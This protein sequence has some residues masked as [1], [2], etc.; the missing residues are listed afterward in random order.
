MVSK[1]LICAS[2]VYIAQ[3]PNSVQDVFLY[4]LGYMRII[5]Y[6][7]II[8][9]CIFMIYILSIFYS[10]IK[11]RQRISVWPVKRSEDDCLTPECLYRISN[12]NDTK[13]ISAKK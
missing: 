7:I 11:N 9:V 5:F 13:S 1:A 4:I 12:L 10:A 6:K 3:T 8:V 2:N